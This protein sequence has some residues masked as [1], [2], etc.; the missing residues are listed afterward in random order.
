MAFPTVHACIAY[1]VFVVPGGGAAQHIPMDPLQYELLSLATYLAFVILNI[2]G[3]PVLLRSMI[4]NHTRDYKLMI[5]GG[6]VPVTSSG[7]GCSAAVEV[8][9]E[10]L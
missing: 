7:Y 2:P 9:P 4:R 8:M 6:G 10:G 5:T 3:E 1:G